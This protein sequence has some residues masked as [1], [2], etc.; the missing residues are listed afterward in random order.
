LVDFLTQNEVTEIPTLYNSFKVAIDYSMFEDGKEIDRAQVIRPVGSVDKAFLLGTATTSENVYRRVK[1]FNPEIEFKV[2]EAM[3]FG[4]IKTK[5]ERYAL[6]INNVSIF[7]NKNEYTEVHQ[8]TYEVAYDSDST[9]V[10]SNFDDYILL[11]SLEHAG[12]E[13]DPIVLN[14][15]PRFLAVS[16]DVIFSDITVANND[17]DINKILE[18]NTEKKY[19]SSTSG[20]DG[21]GDTEIVTPSGGEE[22]DDSTVLIPDE[23]NKPI[24]D[25]DYTPDEDGYYNY[26][27]QCT[28]TTPNALLVVEDTISDSVY[29]VDTMIK[30]SMVIADIEDI[31]VGD[32]VILREAI[33]GLD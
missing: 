1:C 28:E 15:V 17:N 18:E 11:Y 14:Y 24:A 33:D 12:V 5:K 4:V 6:K 2:R 25:G 7:I 3:P 8:S 21:N 10:G 16:L 27:E 30:K 26:Y 20:S 19:D 23:D 9:T 32:Y 29:N 22:G 31:E 13:L